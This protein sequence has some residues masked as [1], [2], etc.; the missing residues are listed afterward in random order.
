MRSITRIELNM[1]MNREIHESFANAREVLINSLPYPRNNT[2]A[3]SVAYLWPTKYCPVGCEHCMFSSPDLK[4][5]DKS[6]ILNNE[7]LEKFIQISHDTQLQALVVSGGGEPMLEMEIIERLIEQAHYS[8][9]EVIT[10]AH[11]TVREDLIHQHLSR[12]QQSITKR[13]RQGHTFE[14]NLR[15]SIDRFHQSVIDITH[16]ANLVKILYGDKHLPTDTQQYPDITLFLRTTLVEGDDTPEQLALAL[17]GSISGMDDFIR[18]ITFPENDE[19][20]ELNNLMVF[21]MD[22]R[23]IGNA[24][25]KEGV[26]PSVSF[27]DY[28]ERYAKKEGDVRLGMSYIRPYSDAAATKGLNVTVLYDGRV[29]PYGGAPDVVYSLYSA[30]DYDHYVTRLFQDVLSFTLL[31]KGIRH[32]QEV[33]E[34]IDPELAVRIKRKNWLASVV[35]ESLATRGLRNYVSVRLLQK[36]LEDGEVLAEQL[37]PDALALTHISVEKL[38]ELYLEHVHNQGTQ[39]FIYINEIAEVTK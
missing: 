7:A 4:H 10:G 18:T 28:Y 38:K 15:V 17:N 8:Y 36:M 23:F 39:H 16:I 1:N 26:S 12:L 11:W 30:E 29:I 37:N 6:M 25:S 9:F 13:K 27:Q 19:G 35:D 31:T 33:A 3:L 24:I 21:Y 14:F 5:V 34:E 22:M 20:H 2:T 32:V